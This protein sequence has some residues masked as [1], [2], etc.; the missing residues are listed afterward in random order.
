[1][2]TICVCTQGLIMA[3]TTAIAAPCKH[4]R[5]MPSVAAHYRQCKSVMSV[6]NK[7][8]AVVMVLRIPGCLPTHE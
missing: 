1:M 6:T 8:S 5:R 7:P 3:Q 4:H 2:G